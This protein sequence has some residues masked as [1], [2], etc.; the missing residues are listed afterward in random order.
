[1]GIDDEID[2]IR[3][4]QELERLWAKSGVNRSDWE[5]R[6]ATHPLDEALAEAI[7]AIPTSLWTSVTIASG[8]DGVP[9]FSTR[10]R[11]DTGGNSTAQ[12]HRAYLVTEP[13]DK[14][15]RTRIVIF[16]DG[17]YA[18]DTGFMAVNDP[19]QLRQL[20]AASIVRDM[21]E[22]KRLQSQKSQSGPKGGGCAVALVALAG[23]AASVATLWPF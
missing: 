9:R 20:V 3:K 14:S 23:G 11:S 7:A 17:R 21:D 4:A 12:A 16:V 10:G 8:P 15:T 22:Q 18:T 13:Y 2:R 1:M 19:D 6:R 5:V